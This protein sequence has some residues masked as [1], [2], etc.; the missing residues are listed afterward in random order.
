M[1]EY[2]P[3][4][5][6]IRTVTIANGTQL[7]TAT[8]FGAAR[9]GIGLIMPATFTGTALTFEVSDS[10]DGTYTALNNES[11]SAVSITVAQNKTYSLDSSLKYLLP[12]RY[13][14]AKSGSSE[15]GTRILT[16]IVK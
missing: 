11:G 2:D 8:D 9:I 10:L 3:I 7:S 16:F 5:S 15:G 4:A 12:W 13:I 14:K 6:G 1:S